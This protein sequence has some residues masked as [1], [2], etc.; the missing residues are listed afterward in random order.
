M[1]QHLLAAKKSPE[2]IIRILYI[3]CL[4]REPAAEELDKL[5]KLRRRPAQAGG[6]PGRHFLEPA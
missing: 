4:S 1:I 3:R 5:K 2:E 6:G